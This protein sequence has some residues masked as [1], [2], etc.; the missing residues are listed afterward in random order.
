MPLSP[1]AEGR[2]TAKG[3][4][5]NNLVGFALGTR[6]AWPAERSGYFST[7]PKLRDALSGPLMPE[8][9]A[10]GR[11]RWDA[12][13]AKTAEGGEATLAV[14]LRAWA[15]PPTPTKNAGVAPHPSTQEPDV[16][17]RT[18]KSRVA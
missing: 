15:A 11:A 8:E 18:R 10:Q 6:L 2:L 14:P 5:L 4:S 3:S 16:K 1:E 17:K 7:G 13:R 12:E 9:V